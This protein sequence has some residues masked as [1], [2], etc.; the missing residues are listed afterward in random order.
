MVLTRARALLVGW[1]PWNGCIY[2]PTVSFGCLLPLQEALQDLQ[3]G[4]I[5][6]PFQWLLLPCILERV[7]FCVCPLRVESLFPITLWVSLKKV[8]LAFQVKCSGGWAPQYRIPGMRSPMQGL[9]PLILGK[10]LRNC[11][12]PSSCAS[13]TW[14]TWVLTNRISAPPPLLT[15]VPSL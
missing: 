6:A 1:P 12:Y 4:L 5:Q 9:D 2:V 15:V 13:L 10:N 11:N 8:P 7:R 3:V 14:G